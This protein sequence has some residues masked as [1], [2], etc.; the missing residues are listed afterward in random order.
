[1][2]KIETVTEGAAVRPLTDFVVPGLS[3]EQLGLFNAESIRSAR[4]MSFDSSKAVDMLERSEGRRVVGAD[5]GGDKG[6]SRLFSVRNG[7]LVTEQEYADDIQGDNGRGYMASIKK[8]A[9]YARQHD[10]PLG[11]SLGQP[12]EGTRPL[13][14]PKFPIF[15]YDLNEEFDGDLINVYP[16]IRLI[17]DAPAGLISG[18]VAARKKFGAETVIFAVNGGGLNVAVLKDRVIYGTEAGHVEGYDELNT[19]DQHSQCGVFGATYTCIEQL[20]ANKA[21]IE[22]QWQA[23]KGSYMRARDIE[24]RYREGDQLAAELYNH[25]AWVVAHMIRGVANVF[26]IKVDDPKVAVVGHGGAF[27]F[28]HYGER[29][30]QILAGKDNKTGNLLLAKDFVSVDS[31][32]CLEGAAILAL[33]N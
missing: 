20:G 18:A 3:D 10:I 7:Q 6:T 25:S 16:R 21:G 14:G 30:M 27:K 15:L 31:N 17:N 33:F 8:S 1:M 22:V 5:F 28:P 26:D 29:V 24:D 13:P 12:L 23:A 11:I 2:S 4:V 9:D 32:A 19:Y